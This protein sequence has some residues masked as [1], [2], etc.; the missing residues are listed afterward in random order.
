MKD[1]AF[2]QLGLKCLV[3]LI[4]P[5]NPKSQNTAVKIGLKHEKDTLRPNGMGMRLFA[6]DIVDRQ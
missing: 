4:D 5:D 2:N 3:A 6:L 1:Y